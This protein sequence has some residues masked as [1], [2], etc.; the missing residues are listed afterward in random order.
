MRRTGFWLRADDGPTARAGTATEDLGLE[1]EYPEG[2]IPLTGKESGIA[3]QVADAI[4]WLV[5]DQASH[6]TGTEVFVDGGQSLI[7]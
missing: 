3:A 4:S 7:A 6:V 2:Q 5:S 1:A